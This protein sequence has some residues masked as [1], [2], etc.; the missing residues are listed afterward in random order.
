MIDK[1]QYIKKTASSLKGQLSNSKHI[2][3]QSRYGRSEACGR[4]GCKN[5]GLMSGEDFIHGP[6]GRKIY[7]APGNCLS[8]NINYA[9][10]CLLCKKN[11]VGRST[12]QQ[13]C[14]N[15]GHRAKYIRYGKQIANGVQMNISD[16]DEE[17]AL[18]IHL[19][20][21]HGIKDAD[22]FDNHFRFTILENCNPRDLG[23]KEHIWM[24]KLRTLYPHGLNLNSPFGLPLLTDH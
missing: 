8:R 15:N 12:Q 4:R 2:T 16:L 6:N 24:Q 5:C 3:L 17:Y 14:R 22:G 18:G 19:H 13:A 10:T 1:F 9:A 21:V 7:T 11:Y 23:K 20:D